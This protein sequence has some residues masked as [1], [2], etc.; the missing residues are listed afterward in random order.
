MGNWTTQEL[1]DALSA[2]EATGDHSRDEHRQDPRADCPACLAWRVLQGNDGGIGSKHV[3]GALKWLRE[4]VGYVRERKAQEA[5]E[6]KAETR[7]IRSLAISIHDIL[8][9]RKHT[10]SYDCCSA[11]DLLKLAEYADILAALVLH[12]DTE[13]RVME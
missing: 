2:Y 7:R 1:A 3:E 11:A 9:K 10:N 4:M 6:N 13:I 12:E 8:A 5:T